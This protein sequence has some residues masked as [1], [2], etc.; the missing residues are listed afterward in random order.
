MKKL[1]ILLFLLAFSFTFVGA[2]SALTIGND[3]QSRS[4]LDT[5][6]N[7]AFIDPT[8]VFTTE[9][10]I[11]SWDIWIKADKDDTFSLQIYRPTSDPTLFTLEYSDNWIATEDID[12]QVSLPVQGNPANFVAQAGDVVGWWFGDG[13]GVI[14]FDFTSDPVDWTDWNT[15]SAQILSPV[16]G[17]TYEF[18]NDDWANS[19]QNREYSVAVNYSPVPEPATIFLIGTGLIGLAGVRRKMKKL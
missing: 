14:P 12:T 7:I 17:D 1:V 18:N 19:S 6:V 4:T 16:I 2:A 10:T 9:G 13:G 15:P 11:D 8:L 5:A 3:I